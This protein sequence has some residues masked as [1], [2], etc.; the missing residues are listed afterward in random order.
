MEIDHNSE[1]NYV[2]LF[3]KRGLFHRGLEI[4]KRCGFYFDWG[5]SHL[6]DLR[7]RSLFVVFHRRKLIT[8]VKGIRAFCLGREV[9][10][11]AVR[12]SANGVGSTMTG[13]S[14]I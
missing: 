10:F 8:I 5:V 2:V 6:T 4:G 1:G 14:H 11:V 3:R 9:S 12:R 7:R 13:V